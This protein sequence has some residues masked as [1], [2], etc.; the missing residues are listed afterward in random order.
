MLQ[1]VTQTHATSS[2]IIGNGV[3]YNQTGGENQGNAYVMKQATMHNILPL[4]AF[5]NQPKQPLVIKTNTNDGFQRDQNLFQP[6]FA[7]NK[8]VSITRNMSDISSNLLPKTNKL[9]P[10]QVKKLL[11][12]LTPLMNPVSVS[13]SS[14]SKIPMAS[15][16]PSSVVPLNSTLLLSP[17]PSNSS[18]SNYSGDDNSTSSSF[19]DVTLNGNG[20]SNMDIS[21][22]LISPSYSNNLLSDSSSIHM[23]NSCNL[24]SKLGPNFTNSSEASPSCSP[25]STNETQINN[26]NCC[27]SNSDLDI[28]DDIQQ[29]LKDAENFDILF[30]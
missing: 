5:N 24:Q 4:S 18:S 25:S 19:D 9:T 20:D 30:A 10:P 13:S 3:S 27:Q 16:S 11:S 28:L 26:M 7:E 14:H 2:R 21:N 12:S 15:V 8:G 17:P 1:N 23:S 29:V 22:C 6:T